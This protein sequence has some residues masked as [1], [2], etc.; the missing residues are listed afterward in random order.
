MILPDVIAMPGPSPDA[1]VIAVPA[2]L[3]PLV[4]RLDAGKPLLAAMTD[5][6]AEQGFSS[7]VVDV[8]GLSLDPMAYV[9][10][11]LSTT[12]RHAA[13]YSDT[14]RPNGPIM[15]E[16]G[17]LTFGMRDGA[18]FFHCHAVWHEDGR[19]CAGHLLP[20][21]CFVGK[22]F[23]LRSFALTGARFVSTPDPETNFTL[24]AP[25]ATRQLQPDGVSPA[26]AVRLRPNVDFH[27]AIEN[28]CAAQG[29]PQARILGGVGSLI[30]A[31]FADGR[32]VENF[33]T[34]V[35]IQS[36]SI[37]PDANGNPVAECAIGLVDYTGRIEQGVLARGNRVLMTFELVIA[38]L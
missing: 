38:P 8:G 31:R 22:A 32:I 35:F 16:G 18:P 13:F 4:L 9:M 30:G 34:E 25:E 3:T 12:P 7:G 33:A 10:P 17:Q 26:L 1:R 19:M 24:F 29:W 6:F 27:A 14:F 21:S 2:H 11:A 23:E 37:T 5:A 36:G 28:L 20:E 15:L